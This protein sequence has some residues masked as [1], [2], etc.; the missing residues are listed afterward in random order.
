MSD[1]LFQTPKPCRTN[2]VV[3]I[4]A[5]HVVALTRIAERMRQ[6][7]KRPISVNYKFDP[8]STSDA[9][10]FLLQRSTDPRVMDAIFNVQ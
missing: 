8:P 2:L 7:R 9:L 3:R 4:N 5:D 6:E 1:P 10:K